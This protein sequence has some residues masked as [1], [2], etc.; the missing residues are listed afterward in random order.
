MFDKIIAR[1][2]G[3][4]SFYAKLPTRMIP[5]YQL[6]F[7]RILDEAD[8]GNL[9]RACNGEDYSKETFELDNLKIEKIV[10][11]AVQ[12]YGLS[13]AYLMVMVQQYFLADFVL[14]IWDT[15]TWVSRVMKRKEI[16]YFPDAWAIYHAHISGI[17]KSNG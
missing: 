2:R 1:L 10:N 8:V 15:K 16:D 3:I 14:R 6:Y 5:L 9:S 17:L 11:E 13:G 7:D 12:K 4:N